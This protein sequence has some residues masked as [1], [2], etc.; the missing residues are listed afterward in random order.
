MK[1]TTAQVNAAPLCATCYDY[2]EDCKVVLVD[3]EWIHIEN[4]SARCP[5]QGDDDT[6][7]TAVPLTSPD[8]G[9]RLIARHYVVGLDDAGYEILGDK[10]TEKSYYGVA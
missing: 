4:E 5:G 9:Q 10:V 7:D 1:L 6:D 2:V 8:N 3:G